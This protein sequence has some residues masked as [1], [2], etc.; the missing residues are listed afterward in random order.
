MKKMIL[1]LIL[2]LTASMAI[3]FTMTKEGLFSETT[4]QSP[5][6]STVPVASN[7]YLEPVNLPKCDDGNPEVQFIRSNDDWS[8]INSSKRI[9][10]VSPGDY[11]S[12]G[13]IKLMVSGT[14]EK[15][16]YIVLNNENDT[17]PGKLNKSE[18]ANFA[19]SFGGAKYWVIDRMASFDHAI[20]RAVILNSGAEHNIFN[21]AFTNEITTFA[22]FYSGAHN[23]TVQNGRFDTM[24]ESARKNDNCTI[25]FY[26]GS[27]SKSFSMKNNK[28]IN[29]EF[30]NQND[31]FQ[32]ARQTINGVL[33]LANCE[34]TIVDNNDMYL[35]SDIYTD[36]QGNYTP[37]GEYVFAEN[38]L[39]LKAAS[40]NAVNPVIITNNHFW[41]Y[42]RSDKS[43]GHCDDA[44][45]ALGTHFNTPNMVIEDNVIFDSAGGFASGDS[46]N[47]SLALESTSIKRNLFHSCGAYP[48]SNSRR[49]LTLQITEA[50]TTTVQ[51]NIIIN[52]R[53][54]IGLMAW[55]KAKIIFTNNKI[56]N[57]PINTEIRNNN[58]GIYN[59][60]SIYHTP[61]EAGYSKDYTFIT[62]K[63]TN[64]PRIMTLKM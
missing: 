64:N 44:G 61:E 34:G 49:A 6:S 10:C 60:N 5:T 11:S 53:E 28:I 19:L 56:I 43:S 17:H 33:Q 15:R 45:F 7:P 32:I 1:S 20:H 52:A 62:D 57:S 12:L 42:R 9:F 3:D 26:S 29:N 14:A 21:R 22:I 36:G 55:N 2:P 63:F 24:K 38:A 4:T 27:S 41:G 23:N 59:P 8:T 48:N 51:N 47:Y 54:N 13:N 30:V 50:D 58:G 16:R 37:V 40:E 39:D 25:L 46:R 18:L 31:S 35:T